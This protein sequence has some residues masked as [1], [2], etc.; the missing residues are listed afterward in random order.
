[1]EIGKLI[2][3]NREYHREAI[4][5]D[6]METI[7]LNM[8]HPEWYYSRRE[9]HDSILRTIQ[10]N[11]PFGVNIFVH[12]DPNTFHDA[13]SLPSIRTIFHTQHRDRHR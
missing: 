6:A 3:A 8:P 9:D 2:E 5:S 7:F 12:G 10:C 11:I 13:P 4:L 1:V